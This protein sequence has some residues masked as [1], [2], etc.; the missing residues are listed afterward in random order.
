MHTQPVW[1]WLST[2][3]RTNRLA[4]DMIRQAKYHRTTFLREIK[5]Y[6]KKLFV[7]AKNCMDSI[8]F[9]LVIISRLTKHRS[10]CA[11]VNRLALGLVPGTN[12]NYRTCFFFRV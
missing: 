3:E 4:R 2:R 5:S 11:F 1:F 10:L 12:Q 8:A 6:K 9:A 7:Y